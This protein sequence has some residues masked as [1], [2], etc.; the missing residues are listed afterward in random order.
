MSSYSKLAPFVLES[1]HGLAETLI[2]S[3][4]RLLK[5]IDN[6]GLAQAVH[7]A[8]LAGTRKGSES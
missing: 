3:G 6:P 8:L 4:T 2:Q 5:V 7:E 1:Y